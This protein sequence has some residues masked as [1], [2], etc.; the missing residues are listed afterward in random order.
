M[1]AHLYL[2]NPDYTARHLAYIRYPATQAD[3]KP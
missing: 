1:P 3:A 2:P